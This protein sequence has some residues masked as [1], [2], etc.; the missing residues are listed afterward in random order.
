MQN[1]LPVSRGV[2]NN[3][4]K[5]PELRLTRAREFTFRFFAIRQDFFP[6]PFIREWQ[7]NDHGA[8]YSKTGTAGASN[9]L[10]VRL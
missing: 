4:T 5:R 2:F 8:N 1:L 10:S 9:R 6:K 3:H 7:E